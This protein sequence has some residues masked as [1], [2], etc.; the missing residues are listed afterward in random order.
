MAKRPRRRAVGKDGTEAHE[1]FLIEVEFIRVWRHLDCCDG[2]AGEAGRLIEDSSVGAQKLLQYASLSHAS[3]SMEK[4][5]R[6]P[7]PRRMSEQIGNPIQGAH[8]PGVLDPSFASDPG[9]SLLGRQ[10]RNCPAMFMQM[11]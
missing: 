4:Q 9:Y 11:A 2:Q 7:V 6:H 5:A 8:T 1:D 3:C 10:Q